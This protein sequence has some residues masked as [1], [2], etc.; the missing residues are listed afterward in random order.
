MLVGLSSP[1]AY[2]LV[3]SFRIRDKCGGFF[4]IRKLL[5]TRVMLTRS[6]FKTLPRELVVNARRF[7]L[8]N[9]VPTK[10]DIPVL[11]TTSA[12]VKMSRHSDKSTGSYSFP[13]PSEVVA[14]RAG[15]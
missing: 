1:H 2:E 4:N 7:E 8:V 5:L 11:V 12:E 3:E 15:G 10:L 9:W 14:G 13:V 6:S